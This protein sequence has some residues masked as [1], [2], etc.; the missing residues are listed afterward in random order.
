MYH[1]LGPAAV[2]EEALHYRAVYMHSEYDEEEVQLVR[3]RPL[4]AHIARKSSTRELINVLGKTKSGR[5]GGR[6]GILPVT[7]KVANEQEF[8]ELI[9]VL[10]YTMWEE[11]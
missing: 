7:V 1:T 11:R 6:S 5:A 9:L 4:R 8:L 3:Q 2:L 10:M